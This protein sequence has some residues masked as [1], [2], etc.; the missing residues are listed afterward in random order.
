MTYLDTSCWSRGRREKLNAGDGLELRE[1][2][3]RRKKKGAGGAKM[4]YMTDAAPCRPSV[5]SNRDAKRLPFCS[6]ALKV[7]TPTRQLITRCACPNFPVNTAPTFHV[8]IDQSKSHARNTPSIIFKIAGHPECSQ[9]IGK[10]CHNK[11]QCFGDAGNKF[12]SPTTSR[13]CSMSRRLCT[14]PSRRIV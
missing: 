9:E 11:G 2:D 13:M 12:I 5:D 8:A 4:C 10:A 6:A 7:M 3:G 14:L 1:T